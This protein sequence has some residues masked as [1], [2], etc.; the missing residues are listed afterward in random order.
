MKNKSLSVI[1]LLISSAF[2]CTVSFFS[3]CAY[4][5][6]NKENYVTDN[7][8]RPYSDFKDALNTKIGLRFGFDIS[9]TFQYAEPG[10]KSLSAQGIYYPYVSWNLFDSENA[11]AGR[12]DFNY[13]LARYWGIEALKLE[14]RVGVAT[15]IND[16]DTDSEI[17][18][19]LSYSHTMPGA[20]NWLS[21]TLGQFPI[22]SFDGTAY[23]ANQQTGLINYSMS[24]NATSSYPSASLGAYLQADVYENVRIA[25]GYQDAKNVHGEKIEFSEAFDGKYTAFTS[26]IFDPSFGSVDGSYGILFYYMP[27]VELRKGDNWG[28]SLNAQQNINKKIA[29][30]GRLNGSTCEELQIKQSYVL[31]MSFLNPLNR[32]S[33]DVITTAAAYNLLNKE[34]FDNDPVMTAETVLETQWV[35]GISKW[36]TLTPDVQLYPKAGLDSSKKWV[37]VA[38]IRTT[39]MF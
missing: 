3:V 35:W 4:A 31:G 38:S 16:Y 22:S 1:A 11:G 9:F 33:L 14:Q 27:S 28:W 20:L 8:L 5:Q 21:L 32:N 6:E 26:V 10:G 2:L 13:N 39:I 18:Y 34:A 37:T 29:V 24:Q 12:I 30:F 25:G 17:F 36:F 7:I 15:A 23:T 19:Q